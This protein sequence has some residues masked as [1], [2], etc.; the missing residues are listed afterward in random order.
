MKKL[1]PI[2]AALFLSPAAAHAQIDNQRSAPPSVTAHG[3]AV[4]TVEPDQAEIDIGVVTQAR[5]APEAARENADKLARVITEIKKILGR[6]PDF[7]DC[8]VMLYSNRH[9]DLIVGTM[10]ESEDEE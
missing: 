2:I 10:V 5:N 6:S 3:E 1:L 4:I 7:A 9:R 8:L